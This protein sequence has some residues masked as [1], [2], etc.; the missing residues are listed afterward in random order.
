MIACARCIGDYYRALR[1]YKK[2]LQTLEVLSAELLAVIRETWLQGLDEMRSNLGDTVQPWGRVFRAGRDDV[3]WPVGGG[4]G[5]LLDLTTLRSM[6]YSQPNE[7]H[8][9]HGFAGQT[10]TQVVALSNPIQSWIYLPVGQP[11]R[12]ESPHYRDQAGTVFSER[13]LSSNC[14]LPGDLVGHIESRMVLQERY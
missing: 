13:T 2:S 6:V 10:S 5:D 7:H 12:L 4:G 14:W 9:R 11:G 3:T 8:E 1:S